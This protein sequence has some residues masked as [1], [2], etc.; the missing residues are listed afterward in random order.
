MKGVKGRKSGR[1]ARSVRRSL[2]FCSRE[3]TT[4]V[5]GVTNSQILDVFGKIEP[6]RFSDR[7][8]GKLG[9]Y[10]LISQN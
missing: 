9:I 10:S 4:A 2:T 8:H 5:E 7:I 3:M 6:I 1:A